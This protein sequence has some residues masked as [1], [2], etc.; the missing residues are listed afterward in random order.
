MQQLITQKMIDEAIEGLGK[1]ASVLALIGR[2]GV[3]KKITAQII[4]PKNSKDPII[5]TSTE[6][7]DE[8]T[9]EATE[10]KAFAKAPTG[11]SPER[12]GPGRPPG[13]SSGQ[14]KG[15]PPRASAKATKKTRTTKSV[16]V[17]T[18]K[19]NKRQQVV[20]KAPPKVEQQATKI[21]MT[22]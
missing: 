3:E 18:T 14:P 22:L 6:I 17:K 5:E 16:V 21:G 1:A 11:K 19:A 12:R 13:K 15:R 10:E 20:I 8:A 7:V 2:V 9:T 4:I